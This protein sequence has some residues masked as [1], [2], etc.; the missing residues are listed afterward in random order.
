MPNPSKAI[1]FKVDQTSLISL[2]KAL[3]ATVVELVDGATASS[4]ARESLSDK[5]GDHL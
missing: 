4:L 1:A 2:R 3:P 5:M